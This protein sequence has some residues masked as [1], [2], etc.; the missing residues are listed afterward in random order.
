MKLPWNYHETTMTAAHLGMAFFINMLWTS[1]RLLNISHR[2]MRA[3]RVATFMSF[4]SFTFRLISPHT[5]IADVS[6]TCLTLV[7][8]TV[9]S[10]TALRCRF[11][12]SWRRSIGRNIFSMWLLADHLL[13]YWRMVAM[14]T[15]VHR[16]SIGMLKSPRGPWCWLLVNKTKI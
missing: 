2:D 11:N 16:K 9:C 8:L 1:D 3:T 6:A 14:P 7:Y 10:P 13:N 4:G 5:N 15:F 12:G